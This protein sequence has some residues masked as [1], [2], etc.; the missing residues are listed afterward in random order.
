[1]EPQGN[2]QEPTQHGGFEQ[3]AQ[4]ARKETRMVRDN[5]PLTDDIV[6]R[7]TQ[8]ARDYMDQR[9]ERDGRFTGEQF[10]R[11]LGTLTTGRGQKKRVHATVLSQILAGTYH[12]TA[13]PYI[14]RIDEYLGR[15]RLRG[16]RLVTEPFADIELARK[17]RGVVRVAQ[18]NGSIGVVVMDPGQGKTTI[19]RAI[20][21][22]ESAAVLITVDDRNGPYG[23]LAQLYEKLSI[24]G[25]PHDAGR[26][27]A[28]AQRLRADRTIVI[29]VDE[30][31][32]LT[33]R[34]LELVRAIHDNAEAGPDRQ[35]PMVLFGDRGFY[36]LIQ[37]GRH[38]RSAVKPQMVR[39]MYPVF[40]SED[41]G[42]FPNRRKGHGLDLYSEADLVRILRN[43][44]LRI[45]TDDGIAY[46]TRLANLKGYGALGTAIAVTRLAYDLARGECMDVADIQRAM[47]MMLGNHVAG[48]L[49]DQVDSVGSAD[50][51][52]A[53]MAAG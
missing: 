16:D 10:A 8:R 26:R 43:D 22:L 44:K 3:L 23:V 13:E 15:E 36:K 50:R 14:R 37:A 27:R 42:A 28:L 5:E 6:R 25:V 51:M 35:I 34:A 32:N 33:P 40:D 46:L 29:L 7:V 39:R 31:Q 9:R 47:R 21:S 2:S 12:G 11:E 30:A 53:A 1:M 18:R 52:Q 45:L 19:A 4:D 48:L 49:I 20:A 38:G 41:P 17:V 24:P